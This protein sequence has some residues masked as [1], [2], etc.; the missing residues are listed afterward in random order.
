[1]KNT[2]CFLEIP[3]GLFPCLLWQI[4]LEEIKEVNS[5]VMQFR[6]FR[7]WNVGMA[8]CYIPLHALYENLNHLVSQVRNMW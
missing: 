4:L 3:S 6:K 7:L 2:V 8:R 5:F 1:V